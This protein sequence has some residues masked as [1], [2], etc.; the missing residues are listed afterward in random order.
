M[1]FST[2]GIKNV[3]VKK[4][5]KILLISTGSE[6]IKKSQKKILPWKVR[7]SNNDYI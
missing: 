4:K 1:A 5:P 2:L 7:N 6:L 3:L